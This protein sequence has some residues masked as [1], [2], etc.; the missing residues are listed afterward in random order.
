MQN[1]RDTLE[2][3]TGTKKEIIIYI[4]NS[5][6]KILTKIIIIDKQ[7]STAELSSSGWSMP[8]TEEAITMYR[9][10]Y[11][12]A[13]NIEKLVVTKENFDKLYEKLSKNS[14]LEELMEV[15]L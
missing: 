9:C 10:P 12:A 11:C 1:L 2:Q 8:I 6:E 13:T 14:S 5:C 7:T 4:C 3:V 15:L